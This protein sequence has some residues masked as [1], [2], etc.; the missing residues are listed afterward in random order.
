MVVNHVWVYVGEV[1]DVDAYDG[2][3]V[4]GQPEYQFSDAP[5]DEPGDDRGYSADYIDLIKGLREHSGCVIH[6]RG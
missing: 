2:R 6:W 3:A 1:T 4:L 5:S